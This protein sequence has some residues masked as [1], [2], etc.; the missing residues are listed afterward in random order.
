MYDIISGILIEGI[1]CILAGMWGTGNGT[2]SY[3]ENIGAIGIT[4][5]GVS[6]LTRC[7]TLLYSF[8]YNSM[9][10]FTM[11]FF[12]KLILSLFKYNYF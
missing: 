5:V 4:R 9:E 2:T 11:F 1:G 6:Y 8:P 7:I 12:Q 3:S 10:S